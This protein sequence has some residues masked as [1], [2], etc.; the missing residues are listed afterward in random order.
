MCH[1]GAG[2]SNRGAA[3]TG[4]HGGTLRLTSIMRAVIEDFHR[5]LAHGARL[6]QRN[7]GF[8]AV[9]LG[10]LALAI[11]ATVT[12]FSI[13]DAWLFRPLNFPKADR[14][15]IAFGANPDRPSEPAVWM[16]YRAYLGWMERSQSFTSVSAA[17]FNGVT[18][19]TPTD[20][21]SALGLEVS[22]EFFATFGVQPLLGRA[23]G[24]SDASGPPVVV[25][26]H[27]F[28]QRQFGGSPSVVGTSITLSDVVHEVVGI[29][30]RDFDVRILDRPEGVEFWTSMRSGADRYAP[31]SMGPVAIIGRLKDGLTI[32]AARSEAAAITRAM[33][34]G[35]QINF[36]QFVVNLASLQQDNTRTVR[37]TLL[38][39]SAAVV[40]LLLI[41]AMNVGSLTLGRG[42]GRMR[43]AAIRA[44]LGSGRARLVRQFLVESLLVSVVGGVCGVGLTIVAIRLFIVWN[45]LGTLPA[46]A[47]ELDL[48]ALAIAGAAMLV[49]TVI[50]GLVPALRVSAIDPQDALRAGGERGLVARPAER[51]QTALLAGQMAMSIVVLV[52]AVLLTQTFLRLNA[53]PLGFD[54]EN[55]WVAS[56][57]LPK[58]P[59]DTAG[60]RNT[61][62]R[63]LAERL[64]SI[65]GISAAAASTMPPLN[66]GPPVTVNTGPEDSPNAPRINAQDVTTQYFAA[67]HVPLLAGRLF[68]AR[69]T[70]G[71]AP[72][73]LFNAQASRQIFGNATAAVGQR[74]RLGKGPWSEIVGVVGN[75]RSSFFNTLEWRTDPILYRPSEQAFASVDNPSAAGFGFFLHIRSDRPLT[76]A[77]V[78]EETRAV[79][80]RAAVTEMQR[81]TDAI[82]MAT[83]QPALRMRLLF[84]FSAVSLLL[85]AIGV[86]GIVSQAVAYR[87]REI[88]IRIAVGAAPLRIITA[89]TRDV[90]VTGVVG[91]GVGVMSALALSRT[92]ETLLYGVRSRDLL[93][94]AVAGTALLSVTL[95]AALIPALKAVRVDPVHVLRAE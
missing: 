66:S 48:R 62:Y 52:A 27:G 72:V 90:C 19:T 4:R 67:L 56:L 89:L 92:L 47:I 22:P 51:A 60:E 68:D 59:F 16:P 37:S 83:R 85:A 50:C 44:A 38:T 69:D 76:L 43:E 10:T 57:T 1:C 17:F 74:V 70:S 81:V 45:P 91:L 77:E 32:E 3:A 82:G 58:E 18:V 23:L 49:T 39:V 30:P 15:V 29:M 33:E 31:G 2:L 75:V 80:S 46:N 8:A 79:S 63:Q 12:V 64:R 34:S 65:P 21:R 73:V 25:L 95:L 93:S 9:V 53:E 55:L 61:F 5:D 41:A 6:L 54:P 35:Y 24:P 14:L 42:V 86:Y 87:L 40:C 11:G 94:F 13:V 28:W 26:S 36:N 71:G 88:A 7:P 20:A 84:A 78:R